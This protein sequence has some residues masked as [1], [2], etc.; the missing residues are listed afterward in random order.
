MSSSFAGVAHQQVS[1][2]TAR[3]SNPES[4]NTEFMYTLQASHATLA[5]GQHNPH[6]YLNYN[7][8]GGERQVDNNQEQ[9]SC[10]GRTYT[11][12]Q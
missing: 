10:S 6:I 4:E 12:L 3:N 2:T 1:N 8:F 7:Q 11:Q 9:P 5:Q